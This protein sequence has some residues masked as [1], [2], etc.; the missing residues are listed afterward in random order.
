MVFL[1]VTPAVEVLD[2]RLCSATGDDPL[3]LFVSI[4]DLLMLRKSRDQGEVA[5]LQ[6]LS[7]LS[8]G[9]DDSAIPSDGINNGVLFAMMMDRGAG[10]WLSEHDLRA[11]VSASQADNCSPT[12]YQMRRPFGCPISQLWHWIVSFPAFVHPC[13]Q[14][15]RRIL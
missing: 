2:N 6:V 11:S 9:T 3:Y 13:L 12:A 7:L 1:A 10:V 14:L 4:I 8:I 5:R 15:C